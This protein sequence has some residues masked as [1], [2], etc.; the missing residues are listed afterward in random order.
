MTVFIAQMKHEE[1]FVCKSLM[2]LI[3]GENHMYKFNH[4]LFVEFYNLSI[5]NLE[6]L[7]LSFQ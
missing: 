5:Y 3:Y 7:I 2:K 1:S 4:L 6:P